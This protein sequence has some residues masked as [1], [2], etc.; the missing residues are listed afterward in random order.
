MFVKNIQKFKWLIC[1]F[2]IKQ[3]VGDLKSNVSKAIFIALIIFC[4]EFSP[5][6][7]KMMSSM[8]FYK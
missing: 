5:I 8:K 7:I 4:I 6:T 2:G 3:F 1:A